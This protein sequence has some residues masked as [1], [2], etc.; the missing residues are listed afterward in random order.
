MNVTELTLALVPDTITYPDSD[1]KPMADNSQ[2]FRWITT[3][4]GNLEIL[5]KDD[6]HVLV[7]GDMLWYPIEGDN[8]TRTAPDVMVIFGRPKGDRGSYQQWREGGLAPQVVF[9]I[10][11]PGN[12]RKEMREKFNFYAWYGVEEYYLYDPDRGLLNGWLRRAGMLEPIAEM[13]GWR[14]PRLGIQFAFAG[15]ELSLFYPDGRPFLTFLELN[16][17]REEAEW[18]AAVE[19]QARREAERRAVTESQARE[20]AEWRAVAE[21]QA[22]EEAEWRAVAEAQAREEAE[23]RAIAEAQAREEAERR[24]IAEAQAR[25]EAEQ[26]VATETQARQEAE[27]RAAELEARLRALEAQR[28]QA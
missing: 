6:P 25:Q 11:S 21:S 14:S 15:D 28:G 23:R 16:Q 12:T 27:Q 26:R 17:A 13:W 9:E 5:F 3:I 22:R 4:E 8:K 24:A 7:V 2:Q 18:R 1:G 20:E 19:S 10:L